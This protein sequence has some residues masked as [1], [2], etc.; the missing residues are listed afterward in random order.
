MTKRVRHL[1]A[2]KALLLLIGG[3]GAALAQPAGAQADAGWTWPVAGE[4]ITPYHNGQD[5]Y[6]GGQHRG[7]DVAAPS[8]TP[9]F[10][11]VEG[12]VRFAG[13]AG[14]SGLTLS[15][16]TGDGR[17]ATSYL[18][19]SSTAVR[20]GDRVRLGQRIAAVGTSGRRSATAPHLHFGVREAG[21]RP[22]YRDPLGLLPPPGTPP[23]REAPRGLPLPVGAPVRLSPAP[24]P[25]RSPAP[26]RARRPVPA[27]RRVRAPAGRRIR[28]PAG[29]RIRMPAGGRAPLPGLGPTLV[30]GPVP[31]TAPRRAVRRAHRPGRAPSSGPAS[32]PDATPLGEPAPASPERPRPSPR[33]TGGPDLGW[34]LACAGLLLAA[35]CLGR[36]GGRGASGDRRR[37]SVGALLRPLLGRR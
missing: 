3:L 22:A 1:A 7:I 12:L 20:E 6:A 25:V 19:L 26:S 29:R 30:P 9:V 4:V 16:R 33:A 36:P 21:T 8:G 10:A 34:A 15:V 31:L 23:V 28:V 37:A 2:M 14:S 17:F 24:E 18:H 27:R 5:A 13:T 35:A 11:A 32:A